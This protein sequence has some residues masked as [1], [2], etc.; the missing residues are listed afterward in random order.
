MVQQSRV[1]HGLL[2]IEALRSHSRTHTHT[3]NT[4]LLDVVSSRR[5]DLYLT[6]QNTNKRQIFM[7]PAGFERTVP[8]SE[9]THTLYRTATGTGY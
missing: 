7:P 1:G 6:A 5:R 3:L 9:Q 2:I 4:T 8:E